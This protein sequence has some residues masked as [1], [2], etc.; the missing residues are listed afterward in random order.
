MNQILD[1]S[2]KHLDNLDK[3]RKFNLSIGEC[4]TP[5]RN[6][7]IYIIFFFSKNKIKK[8]N[9]FVYKYTYIYIYFFKMYK[10]PFFIRIWQLFFRKFSV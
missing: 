3:K 4:M 1:S 9:F 7:Y 2:H 5:R 8:D 10:Y 6:I